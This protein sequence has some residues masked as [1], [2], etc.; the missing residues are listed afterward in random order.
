MRGGVFI[1]NIWDGASERRNENIILSG[2]L[3]T[4]IFINTNQDNFLIEQLILFF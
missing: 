1:N 3:K 2:T 4:L